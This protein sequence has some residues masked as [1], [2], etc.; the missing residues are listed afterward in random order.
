MVC[1]S[2][3]LIFWCGCEPSYLQSSHRFW[4]LVFYVDFSIFS[5]P[6]LFY[7][8]CIHSGILTVRQKYTSMLL[9]NNAKWFQIA[10][11]KQ[12]FDKKTK[13][14]WKEIGEKDSI[15]PAGGS[16]EPTSSVCSS[17]RAACGRQHHS[18]KFKWE[19]CE[20]MCRAAGTRQE[21]GA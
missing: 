1:T 2:F 6:E 18:V 15:A 9:A 21:A 8:F 17:V 12:I 19:S 3:V 13:K 5:I 4:V 20:L 11:G 16:T 7:G 10:M 14:Q